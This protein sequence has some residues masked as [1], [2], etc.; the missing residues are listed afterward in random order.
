MG[1][2]ELM[3]ERA[4]TISWHTLNADEMVYY[5][6]V[7]VMNKSFEDPTELIFTEFNLN[8]SYIY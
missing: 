3:H 4:Y 2:Y 7:V 8:I 5:L 6:F 1:L